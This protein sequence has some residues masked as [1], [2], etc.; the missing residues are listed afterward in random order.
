M[1]RANMK[2]IYLYL[3][4]MAL[5]FS[6]AGCMKKTVIPV[7][8]IVNGGYHTEA[9]LRENSVTGLRT[10]DAVVF[11]NVEGDEKTYGE[12]ALPASVSFFY[13][14]EKQDTEFEKE[15]KVRNLLVQK[16]FMVEE[17]KVEMAAG[18]LPLEDDKQKDMT[19]AYTFTIINRGTVDVDEVI[20][21]DALPKQFIPMEAMYMNT[22]G[23]FS[24]ECN[25]KTDKFD[26]MLWEIKE[27]DGVKYFLAK[28]TMKEKPLQPVRKSAFSDSYGNN[29]C[30]VQLALT[31]SLAR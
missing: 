30:V 6:T 14:K 27:H 21:I 8:E 28:L 20:V 17:A 12:V 25:F 10:G 2:N 18:N 15:K 3:A 26:E 4:I 11:Y 22:S 16:S 1:R 9:E 19:F 23:S 13:E 24:D 5:V 29:E 7:M 31:G